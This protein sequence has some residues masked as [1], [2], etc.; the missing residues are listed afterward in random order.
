MHRKP[1]YLL[2]LF[3]SVFSFFLFAT[4]NEPRGSVKMRGYVCAGASLFIILEE[5]QLQNLSA[6]VRPWVFVSGL[7]NPVFLL[8][9]VVYWIDRGWPF[10]IARI[11]TTL[12]LGATVAVFVMGR[13]SPREG[14][15]FWVFGILLALYSRPTQPSL[16]RSPGTRMES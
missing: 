11:V 13:D 15:F 6:R 7:I 4:G 1:L 12:L 3:L 10:A 2:G 5:P 16:A 9:L 8:T 14:Y